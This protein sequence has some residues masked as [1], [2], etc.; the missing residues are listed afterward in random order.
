MVGENMRDDI[1]G[2]ALFLTAGRSDLRA[3]QKMVQIFFT[4]SHVGLHIAVA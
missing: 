4:V 1:G 2:G 3:L